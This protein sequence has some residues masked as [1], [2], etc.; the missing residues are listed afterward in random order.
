M[1]EKMNI[2]F[3]ITDQQRAD[4]L[5]CAGNPV[6]KTPNLDRLA[7]ESVRFTNMYV[8]NPICMPNRASIFTGMYPN[9]HGNRTAG[10]NLSETVPTFTETLLKKGYYTKSIGKIHLQFSTPPFKKEYKSAE[11]GNV[12]FSNR[13]RKDMTENFP[14]PYYG[15]K[16]VDLIVGHGEI[17]SGHYFNWL[18]ERAPHYIEEIKSKGWSHIFKPYY[19][20]SIPEELYPTSYI[21]ERATQF[22]ERYS[23]GEYGDQPFF[24]MCSYPDPHHPVNPPGKYQKMYNPEDIELPASFNDVENLKNHKFLGKL[25]N[26]PFFRGMIL[27]ITT[28]EEAR[29]FTAYTYGTLSMID[30]SVGQILAALEKLGLADNTIVIYTSDHGDLM[31][32]HGLILKGPCPFNGILNVPLIWKVPGV[33]KPGISNSLVSSIDISKTILSLIGIKPRRQPN[34]MQG[35]DITPI[36][37]DPNEKVR[38]FCLVEHDEEIENLNVKTRLRHFIT[39]DYKLTVYNSI[40]GYGDLFDRKN[41]PLELNNLWDSHPDLRHKLLEKLFWENLNAQSRYPKRMSM[42]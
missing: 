39:E 11:S 34:D 15:F 24:L 13:G 7:S 32:D 19:D 37:K 25:L 33:T 17:C 31:G 5:G 21:T 42:S 18:E 3:L 28:E 4:H 27:R 23:Q 38:D 26:N 36:L 16:D 6:L 22:L 1:S 2:L 30:D 8:A 12:W 20:T 14:L 10:V 29:S 40:K 35:V 41:D 9:M